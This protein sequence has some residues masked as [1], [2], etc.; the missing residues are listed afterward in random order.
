[1]DI[2]AYLDANTFY[3][4]D[5]DFDENRSVDG[6]G[7]NLQ[8]TNLDSFRLV[9]TS[10]TNLSS[11]Q[12]DLTAGDTIDIDAGDAVKIDAN[13]IFLDQGGTTVM[14]INS[15]QEVKFASSSVD[16]IL[17]LDDTGVIKASEYGDGPSVSNFATIIGALPDGTLVDIDVDDVLARQID[18]TIYNNDGTLTGDRTLTGASNDLTFTGL[19]D[20]DVT[21]TDGVSFTTDT[22]VVTGE[23]RVSGLSDSDDAVAYNSIIGATADGTLINVDPADIL[24]TQIDSTI[25]NNDGTLT[26]DRTLTGASN[27]LTFTGLSDFDVSAADGVSFTTDTVAVT[28]ETRVSGLGDTDDGITYNSIVGATAD[29]TLINIDA[30]DILSTQTDSTI[31]NFDGTLTGD[32]TLTGGTND[33]TFTD[34]SEFNITV[35]DSVEINGEVRISGLDDADDGTTFASIVGATADGSLIN[36]TADDILATQED[37]TI[38]THDGT[39][40]G[41]RTMTMGGNNLFF[42]SDSGSDTTAIDSSGRMIIGGGTFTN[43]A[44]ASNVKLEVKGDILAVQIHSSSDRRFKKNISPVEGALRKVMGLEGVNYDF[45][46]DEFA[47][48]NFPEERQLGFIAQDIEEFLPEVVRTNGDG[49]KAVDY[50]KVTALLVEAMKEQQQQIETLKGQLAE[51]TDTNQGLAKEIA[52]IKAM[53]QGVS[54]LNVADED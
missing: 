13:E 4:A 50:S 27:D 40:T 28:G 17:F 31:Y 49:Y 45:R 3:R 22:V 37:S 11:P 14:G 10:I 18:S 42:V 1:M 41:E 6:A 16:S 34:L 20:F 2:G 35:T 7:F 25:Y 53:L 43:G 36:V 32:R 29:G 33:L 48:R 52:S 9:S 12:I 30:S 38:Y 24:S 23:N 21:A 19:S 51:A 26:G 39:L 46:T 47:N 8:F 44:I 54:N 15:T 5:G